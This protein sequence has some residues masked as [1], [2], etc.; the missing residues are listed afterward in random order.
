[1]NLRNDEFIGDE[2]TNEFIGDELWAINL[3]KPNISDT[4]N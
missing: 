2:F 1:M 3:L 4:H